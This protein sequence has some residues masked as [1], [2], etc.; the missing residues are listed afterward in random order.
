MDINKILN[1]GDGT[2]KRNGDRLLV[3]SKTG[4]FLS[5]LFVN[6]ATDGLFGATSRIN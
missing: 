5:Y 6:C 2:P 4:F 1:K 3:F